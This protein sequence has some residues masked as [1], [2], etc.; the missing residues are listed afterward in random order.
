MTHCN[1]WITKTLAATLCVLMCSTAARA[2]YPER[3]IRYIVPSAAGGLPDVGARILT[4]ELSRL[5][6]QQIVVDNRAGAGGSIGT[7]IIARAPPDGYTLGA[8]NIQTL[9]INRILLKLPYDAEKDL[10]KIVH[11]YSTPNVLAVND[12]LPARSVKELVEHLRA[13]P[14]KLLH[15][16]VIGSSNHLSSEMF[17]LMTGTR[18]SFVPYKGAQQGI[19]EMIGGQVQFML[20][21]S[22]A[23]LPHVRAGRVRGLAV[24]SALRSR[25]APDLPTMDEAGVKG[26]D[27]TAWSGVIAPAGIP[28]GM[29]A[30]IHAETSRVLAVSAIRDKLLAMGLEATGSTREQFDQFVRSEATK[31]AD[32]VKRS[33]LKLESQ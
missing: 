24:S 26:F 22:A 32:V 14:G 20:E 17:K 13:N 5:L 6:G 9:A 3:P 19:T 33:G 7:E 12:A 30:R 10:R 18:A 15:A 28:A 29:V 25:A 21:N 31:W 23:L 8:G 11:T 16:G 1:L 27:V 4:G 2:Q